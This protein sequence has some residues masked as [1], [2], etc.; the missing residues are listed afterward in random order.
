MELVTPDFGTIFWM[1]IIFL[2]VVV[3]LKKFAWKPILNAMNDREQ[4]I[5]NALGAAQ[6]AR[7]EMENLKA[8]NVQ[9][10]NEARQEREKM[11][12]EAMHLKEK[13]IAEAK[14]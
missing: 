7:K 13:I 2:F 6:N 5:E 8:G 12:N 3:I 4:S 10:L 9:L 1:V 11:L 14:E